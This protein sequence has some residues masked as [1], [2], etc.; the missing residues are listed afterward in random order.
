MVQIATQGVSFNN[1][2]FLVFSLLIPQKNPTV[3]PPG[4]KRPI[5]IMTIHFVSVLPS[6]V[7]VFPRCYTYKQSICTLIIIAR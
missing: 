6:V 2:V 3:F 7:F 5:I 1:L 4:V